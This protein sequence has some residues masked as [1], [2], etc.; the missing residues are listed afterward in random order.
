M[1]DPSTGQGFFLAGGGSGSRQ[2]RRVEWHFPKPQV[3]RI[4]RGY[5]IGAEAPTFRRS[6]ICLR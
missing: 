5:D 3:P 1:S 4:V 6:A 2:R